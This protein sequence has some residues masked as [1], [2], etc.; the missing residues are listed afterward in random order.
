MRIGR[1]SSPR[2]LKYGHGE[3]PTHRREVVQK[4]FQCVACFE[5]VKQGLD[6]YAGTAKHWR[7]AVNLGVNG[8][9]LSVHGDSTKSS[10]RVVYFRAIFFMPSVV[11][12]WGQPHAATMHACERKLGVTHHIPN[13]IVRSLGPQ[14]LVDATQ[15]DRGYVE[16]VQTGRCQQIEL[17]LNLLSSKTPSSA[18][19]TTSRQHHERRISGPTRSLSQFENFRVARLPD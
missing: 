10:R 1:Q 8:D 7:S 17:T 14:H 6:W 4:N 18:P 2:F 3:L 13:R 12:N 11:A 16:H 19:D 9:Q 15:K 5:M